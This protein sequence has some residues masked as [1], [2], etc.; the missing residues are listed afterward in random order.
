MS[1][2]FAVTSAHDRW[3]VRNCFKQ[4]H[5]ESCLQSAISEKLFSDLDCIAISVKSH[6]TATTKE[7]FIDQRP[8]FFLY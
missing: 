6:N 8:R 3:P 4:I 1:L 7:D 5:V 2:D